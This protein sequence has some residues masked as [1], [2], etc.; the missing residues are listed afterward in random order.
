MVWS[1]SEQERR[2]SCIIWKGGMFSSPV[3][4]RQEFCKVSYCV[5][6]FVCHCLGVTQVRLIL[7]EVNIRCFVFC[8]IL[9]AIYFRSGMSRQFNWAISLWAVTIFIWDLCSVS[10][11]WNWHNVYSIF[12]IL[13]LGQRTVRWSLIFT[14]H[15]MTSE[16]QRHSA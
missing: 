14:V 11:C 6:L 16:T 12:V 5:S 15:P 4:C 13:N 3:T 2:L 9:Q 8:V 7:K 1:D 10:L